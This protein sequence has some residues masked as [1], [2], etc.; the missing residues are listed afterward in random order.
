MASNLATIRVELIANAQKFKTNIEKAQKPLKDLTKATAKTTKGSKG[1]QNTMR[2][3][4]GSIAA[5][6][7]PLGPVAG[8]I[9]AIGAIM[10]RVSV[11]G[12]LL[13]GGLV[14]IGASF[15]KM[16][17]AGSNAESQFLKLE[18]LLKAT[19]GASQQTGADIEQMAVQIGQGT[20]A[21]VQGVRDAAGVLLTFKSISGNTFKEVLALS[22]D[23]A[24]VGFGSVKTA[25]LQLGK[26]LEEP[27]IGLSALRRVGVS[28]SE[29]QKEMIKV[30]SLTGRQ[31]E[32]QAMILKALKEQVGGAGEGAAGG[33]AGAFDTLGENITLFFEQSAIASGTIS[34]LT[35]AVQGLADAIGFFVN[36]IDP[37]EE[38]LRHLNTGFEESEKVI[39]KN[40]KEINL[41]EIANSKLT[42]V[43][44]I[45]RGEN[46]RAIEV[47]EKEIAMHSEMNKQRKKKI[48]FHET[49]AEV[50]NKTN[51]LADKTIDSLIRQNKNELLLADSYGVNTDFLKLKIALEKKLRAKL[52]EGEIATKAITK[53]VNER[54]VAMQ[55]QAIE[56]RNA[57][58]MIRNA[59]SED[60]SDDKRLRTQ[61][62][63]IENLKANA[64]QRAL[65]NAIRAEENR[66]R[67]LLKDLD[68]VEREQKVNELIKER[69]PLL[70]KQT[71]EFFKLEEELKKIN[72]IAD[73]VGD[74]FDKAG[75][76]IV[77]A[78]LRGKVASLDFKDILRELIIQIQKTIIQTLILDQVN[79]FVKGAIKGFFS[80]VDIGGSHASGG[81]IQND[82]PSLVGE[83][84]PELFVPNSAGKIINGADT[85][86][87]MGGGGGVS[88]VQNLNF[89]VG[90]TNTVRAE[91]MNMLPAIQQS[92]VQ[93]VADAKQ[94]GGKFSKAF[95]S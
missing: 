91:V 38:S 11:A 36:E 75:N 66:L 40:L 82:R 61:K 1:M 22:Q 67:G 88:I 76:K 10:G 73:G 94:R 20:L 81:T 43:I 4:A 31:A 70:T 53:A 7:G 48:A 41:L 29:E 77:D 35:S 68:P 65:L 56:Q 57:L 80:P 24:A 17:K 83:R 14:A 47:M 5:V 18:A 39:A 86:S 72:T 84:G 32:A 15:V 23:L 54:T 45:Q 44:S 12:L 13:T 92:T 71:E 51:I 93:A 2:D 69:I 25:A 26:A 55:V 79:S 37:L 74:A 6:Q 33:L 28:F 19:G 49:E 95:G 9:S 63:E 89:A 59:R 34:L 16:V 64:K 30:M 8:R 3:L 21:S 87:A 42:S 78:F 60:D 27:E 50:I 90:V 62:Q 52:G 85:K 46:N 58:L